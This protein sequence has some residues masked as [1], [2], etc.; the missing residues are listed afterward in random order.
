M[1]FQVRR[2]PEATSL[3]EIDIEIPERDLEEFDSFIRG[4]ENVRVYATNRYPEYT[5]HFYL[6]DERYCQGHGINSNPLAALKEACK[7]YREEVES[8]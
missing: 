5:W 8:V 3:S 7:E 6:V 1:S 4:L 2:L